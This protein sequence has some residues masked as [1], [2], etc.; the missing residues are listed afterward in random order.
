MPRRLIRLFTAALVMPG[1]L[2]LG[3][4]ATP[5][6]AGANYQKPAVGLC[7]ALSLEDIYRRSNRSP[8]VPCAQLHTARTFAVKKLPRRLSWNS[9]DEKTSP[10]IDRKCGSAFD[11]LMGRGLKAQLRSAYTWAFFIPTRAQVAQGARWFRCDVYLHGGKFKISP[12]PAVAEPA[13]GTLP[14]A[15][16][17]AR[18]LTGRRKWPTVCAR[19]HTHRLLKVYRI[20]G[21]RYPSAEKRM[22]IAQRKCF[23]LLGS[24]PGFQRSPSRESWRDGFRFAECFRE[25]TD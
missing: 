6:N 7:R 23:P 25:T 16:G 3:P 13:L 11:E 17:I 8:A 4:L 18:C 24:E 12:L 1:L 20:K 5:A 19:P 21:T 15:D 9:P 14:F 10:I 2:A 22:A